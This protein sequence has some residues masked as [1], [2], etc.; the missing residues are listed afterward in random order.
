MADIPLLIAKHDATSHFYAEDIQAHGLP[1]NQLALVSS[2]DALTRDA[3]TP[4]C[5]PTDC[6]LILLRH[7]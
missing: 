5:Y 1:I 4:G 7:S 3:Y 6:V 2:I